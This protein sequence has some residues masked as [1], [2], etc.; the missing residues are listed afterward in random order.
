MLAGITCNMSFIWLLISLQHTIPIV[1][2]TPSMSQGQA[3]F[4]QSV[5]QSDVWGSSNAECLWAKCRRPSTDGFHLVCFLNLPSFRVHL[6][7]KQ[8]FFLKSTNYSTK[9][10][11][12]WIK[13]LEW[14]NDWVSFSTASLL[15]LWVKFN[16][17]YRGPK[18]FNVP[19]LP[20]RQQSPGI[21]F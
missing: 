14:D 2:C 20:L 1:K 5:E 7:E 13:S 11:P 4:L 15:E 18:S 10:N 21:I 8:D 3:K 16:V 9:E 19:A 6:E 12:Y 17:V